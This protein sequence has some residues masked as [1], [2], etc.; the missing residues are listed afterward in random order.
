MGKSIQVK[1]GIMGIYVRTSVDKE[2]TSIEQQKKLGINFCK[3]NNFQYYIYE[4]IGKSG[5]K[6]EDENNPFKNRKGLLKLISDIENKIIDKVWV[7][8][9][10]RLS[11][12][13]YSSFLLNRIFQKYNI[14]IYELDKQYDLNNPQNKMI[15]GILTQISQYE[16]HLI[17]SRTARGVHDIINSGIHSFNELYGY[18]RDGTK[19]IILSGREKTYINWKPFD[20]EIKQ[21]KYAFNKI[22][23]G[24]SISQIILD[25][26]KSKLTEKNR[27]SLIRKFSAILRQF[28]YTG[29]CL[30]IE[31][32][33]IY[34]KYKNFEIDSIKELKNKKYYIKSISYP[35]QIISIDDWIKVVE[36]IN[37]K[38][39]IYK[40]R[41]RRTNSE[42]L[43][44]IMSCPYCELHY[45]LTNDK[46]F[47]Y[48]KH[49]PKKLC[50]QKPKSIRVEKLNKYFEIFF[51]YFYLVYDDTKSLMEENQKLIDLN[52][53]EIK[54]KIK[55]IIESNKRLDNQINKIQSVYESSDDKEIIKLSL[56]KEND[57]S[58]KKEENNIILLQLNNE[59]ENLIIKYNND[60]LELTYY[61][62][63]ELI[64]NFFEKMNNEEKRTELIKIISNFQLFGK[65]ILIDTG[66]LLFIFNLDNEVILSEKIYNKFKN[67]KRFKNNFLNSSSVIDENGILNIINDWKYF[68]NNYKNKD[69]KYKE[70]SENEKLKLIENI[71]DYFSVR[72]LDNIQIQEIYL[73]SENDINIKSVIKNQLQ[74]IGID[75]PLNNIEKIISFTELF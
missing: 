74:N 11:R 23:E 73:K 39:L 22:L 6:I 28:V 18:K 38:R 32:Q 56:K 31:G 58:I 66:K 40:D 48:Y 65:Y 51:F 26:F 64:T 55:S 42:M 27:S 63:I 13:D 53:L 29:Y 52:L 35:I 59:L 44:G 20:S 54:D 60:K 15:Q 10:S 14:I 70:L 12:N 34:R 41:M 72:I 9:H 19:T 46:D 68:N 45:Y 67:D 2:N 16:R 47:I 5:F 1:S 62:V 37:G 43:T 8:E 61:N 21:I 75:Y 33:E 36:K 69:F 57:L 71:I 3:K 24:K 7:F 25:I 50:N 49:F 30:N 17:T 4:D